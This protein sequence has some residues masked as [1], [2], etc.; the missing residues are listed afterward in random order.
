MKIYPENKSVIVDSEIYIEGELGYIKIIFN[1]CF[2]VYY[3]L[4]YGHKFIKK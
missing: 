2:Y 4:D 1:D 3:K